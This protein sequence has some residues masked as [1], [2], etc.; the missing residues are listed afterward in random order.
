M[1][2]ETS[3]VQDRTLRRP[4]V[5]KSSDLL[6]RPGSLL[7]EHADDIYQLRITAKGRLILTKEARAVLKS[8]GLL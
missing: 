3:D 2:D 8:R 6:G 1:V 7:I 5:V 4:G